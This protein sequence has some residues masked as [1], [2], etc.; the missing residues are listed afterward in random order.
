MFKRSGIKQWDRQSVQYKERMNAVRDMTI[1][2][3]YPVTFVD[4]PGVRNMLKAFGPKFP[5]LGD[6]YVLVN[7]MTS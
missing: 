1:T 3:G 6:K 2:T 4:Q 5:V 7:Y